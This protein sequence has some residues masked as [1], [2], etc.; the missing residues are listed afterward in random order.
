MSQL[1][2]SAK[3]D[4]PADLAAF[5][6]TSESV[7]L[8]WSSGNAEPVESYVIEYGLADGSGINVYEE[9]EDITSVEYTLSD[10]KA[11]TTYRLRVS[12]VNNVGRGQPTDVVNFSTKESGNSLLFVNL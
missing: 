9:V 10:L 3:P 5:D 7:R 11:F 8:R 4:P 2:V 12:A 6:A 1:F